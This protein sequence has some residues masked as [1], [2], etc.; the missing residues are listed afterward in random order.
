M[1]II[2]CADLHLDSGMET[3]LSK[4]Q[5][6]ERKQELL[7]TF[8]GMIDYAGENGVKVIIIAGDLFDTANT[9]QKRIKSRVLDLIKSAADID[10]IYLQGNHDRSDYFATVEDRPANLK[11]FGKEWSSFVYGNIVITGCELSKNTRSSVYD[12]LIL[13]EAD[14]NIVVLHGQESQYD[15]KNDAEIINLRKL[16]NRYIDYLA[17]G[18]IH[19]Y[20]CEKLDGRGI[21]CYSGCLE[22]RGF[23]ECGDKGFV[24]LDVEEGVVNHRF[25][26][27]S[28]RNCHEV[29]VDIGSCAGERYYRCHRRKD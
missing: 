19:Q 10:F 29:R 12:E 27:F 16:A 15:G 4:E 18:H 5:A 13:R 25:I 14:T 7:A 24:L 21:Y 2:H 1:R 9:E 6:S 28:K 11:M 17:L 20:K 3:N 22:G 8:A 26:A 23:D